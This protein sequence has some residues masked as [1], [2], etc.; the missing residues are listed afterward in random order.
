MATQRQDERRRPERASIRSS[1]ITLATPMKIGVVE[2]QGHRRR[3]GLVD[4]VDEAEL[5]AEDEQGSER[6]GGMAS[7]I[8]RNWPRG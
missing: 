1:P 2:E 6:P 7:A 3:R 5:V 8:S 4:A